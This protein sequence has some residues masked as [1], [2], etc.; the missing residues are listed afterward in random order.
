MAVSKLSVLWCLIVLAISTTSSQAVES[1]GGRQVKVMERG[2]NWYEAYELC[3][4]EQMQLLVVSS[5]AEELQTRELMARNG[6]HWIWLGANRLGTTNKFVWTATGE[7]LTYNNWGPGEPN[8]VDGVEHCLDM[9]HLLD[10]RR[11]WNDRDCLEKYPFFCQQTEE[12]VKPMNLQ[13]V[14]SRTCQMRTADMGRELN[15]LRFNVNEKDLQLKDLQQKN[16]ASEVLK[17]APDE[18]YHEISERIKTLN[19]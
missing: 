13:E 15:R 3:R 10:D 11:Y 17:N 1:I 2:V 12:R 6:W 4:R 19:F 14:F 16:R 7:E 8:N 5:A 18:R 9:G